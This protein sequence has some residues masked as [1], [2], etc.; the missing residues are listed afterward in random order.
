VGF[1]KDHLRVDHAAVT[2]PTPSAVGTFAVEARGLTRTFEGGVGVRDLDLDVP[3]GSIFGFIGPSG[4]G[5]TTTVRLMTG[6]LAPESGELRVLGMAPVDFDRGVRS[7][8]GYMPQ[9]NALYP[10]LT[11]WHNLGFTA[12]LFGMPW[13]GRRRRLKEAFNF[14]ELT[15]AKERLF[16]NASGGMKRRIALAATLIHD[17]DLMFLDE[18]T[19]GIDPV[20]RKKIWDRFAELRDKGRTLFVTTQYV[21][22]AA[23][24]DLVGVL[25]RGRLLLVATPEDL[26]RQAFGGEVLDV[27]FAASPTAEQID[28]IAQSAGAQKVQRLSQSEIRLVV[29]AAGDAAVAVTGTAAEAGVEIESV[30]PFLPPFD[31]VFVEL[32]SKLDPGEEN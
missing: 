20:L 24:C 5:K 18:P 7:R 16:Q 21:G 28:R 29:P 27:T 14:V 26:R 32:V 23:Y 22:E 19:G 6:I 8:L 31:D 12:S 15:D 3:A 10:D 30:E 25:A 4:S 1:D 17:P 2:A 13:R 9:Q 11:L